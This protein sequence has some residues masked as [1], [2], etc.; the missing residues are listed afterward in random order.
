MSLAI[1]D[2]SVGLFAMPMSAVYVLLGFWPFGLVVCHIWLS[3]DYVA[4]TASIFNLFA[5][6]SVTMII[7]A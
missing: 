1:A 6:V 4:S 7:R 2:C 5:L 3:L